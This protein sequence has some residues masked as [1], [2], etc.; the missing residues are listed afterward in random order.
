M[1]VTSSTSV[2]KISF[3]SIKQGLDLNASHQGIF[4]AFLT[5]KSLTTFNKMLIL[6][7]AVERPHL[8]DA[9]Y[10]QG[11]LQ[12][13]AQNETLKWFQ[14]HKDRL[15]E[16]ATSNGMVTGML[17]PQSWSDRDYGFDSATLE[18]LL[19]RLLGL[20]RAQ[21]VELKRWQT[22]PYLGDLGAHACRIIED[23]KQ[24]STC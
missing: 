4:R 13:F 17:R 20:T 3:P 18:P 7:F 19:A 15:N 6:C 24:V 14:R 1:C 9:P 2:S 16:F 8:Q 22:Q 11:H 10:L 23:M 12:S 21:R 5:D